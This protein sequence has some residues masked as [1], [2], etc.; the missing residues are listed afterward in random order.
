MFLL[1]TLLAFGA[2]NA[3]QIGYVEYELPASDTAWKIANQITNE[4][5]T[6][7]VY[8]H[9]NKP[10]EIAE[11]LFGTHWNNFPKATFDPAAFKQGIQANFQ[12][13]KIQ[14]TLVEKSPGSA[15]CEWTASSPDN[16]LLFFGLVR[17]FS[18]DKGN[19]LLSFQSD[20]PQK[21][22][23][24]RPIWLNTLQKAQPTD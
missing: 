15:I 21:R 9:E 5:C 19:V 11:E 14:V 17:A 8:F 18:S 20:Q 10:G 6:Q 1:S 3:E 4:V 12:D 22:D 2:L 24:L 23:T 7:C 16:Q 13:K